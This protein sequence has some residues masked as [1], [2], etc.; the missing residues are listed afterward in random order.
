MGRTASPGLSGEV[1][2]FM[3]SSAK[4]ALVG[5]LKFL[6]VNLLLCVKENFKIKIKKKIPP[7]PLSE[8]SWTHLAAWS[9]P[10]STAIAKSTEVQA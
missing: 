7:P 4:L 8:D 6:L 2:C 9:V 1:G 10:I 5:A 3:Y